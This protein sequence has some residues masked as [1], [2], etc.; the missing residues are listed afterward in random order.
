VEVLVEGAVDPANR[1]FESVDD[2]FAPLIQECHR[3]ALEVVEVKGEDDVVGVENSVVA[4]VELHLLARVERA[5]TRGQYSK[6]S[7]P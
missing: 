2:E 3:R 4:A 5:D 7:W 6:P 1:V